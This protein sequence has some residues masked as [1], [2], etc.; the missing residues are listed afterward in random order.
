MPTRLDE[1]VLGI[2]GGGTKTHALITNR[3]GQPLGK[4]QG[5]SSNYDDVGMNAAQAAIG[6]AVEQARQSAGLEPD[7]SFASVFLGMAGVVSE[8]DRSVI[9]QIA[10][11][12]GLGNEAGVEVDHD[13]RIALAGGL[14]GRPGI[15]QITGTGSSTYGRTAAGENWR[16]GGWGHLISDEGS[17]YFYGLQA[18]RAATMAYDGRGEPTQLTE[19]VMQ[20][21]GLSDMQEIMHHV[22][23]QGLTRAE[24]AAL[25]P[26]VVESAQSG[27]RTALNL[28]AL[29]SEEVARCVEAVARR[30]R[31]LDGLCE[32]ALVGGLL[33][34]G[35]VII[36]PLRAAIAQRLPNSRIQ[37]AELSPVAGACLLAL[38]NLGIPASQQII[39]ALQ[40]M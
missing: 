33:N 21:L 18:M 28:I 8:Q 14:A 22:Y 4:G 35:D 23:A 15:V 17:S 7:C 32:V 25:A 34:A 2:D 13:C 3:S 10:Q 9:Y 40:T 36:Q 26:L 19:K 27:D 37:M 29:G 24:T 5:P 38:Q 12:L 11:N 1:V 31:M 20:A 30:L 39:A 16:S 6:Q